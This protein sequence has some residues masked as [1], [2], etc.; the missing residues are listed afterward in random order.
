MKHGMVRGFSQYTATQTEQMKQELSIEMPLE[1]LAYC[2]AYYQ[3]KARRDPYIEELK[4]LDRF[5]THQATLAQ[6]IAPTGLL[7]NHTALAQTYADMMQKRRELTENTAA[8]PATLQELALLCTSY[9]SRIGRTSN[10]H[11]SLL[12]DTLPDENTVCVAGSR[13]SNHV[14]PHTNEPKNEN[15]FFVLLLPH[16]G[17]NGPQMQNA[18][19]SFLKHIHRKLCFKEML[20]VG[21]EGLLRTL[22]MLSDGLLIDLER[23][24]R[25][26][27]PISATMLTNGYSGNLLFRMASDAYRTFCETANSFRLCAMAFAKPVKGTTI[28]VKRGSLAFT[29]DTAFLRGLIPILTGEAKLS[30]TSRI[31]PTSIYHTSLTAPACR[32]LATAQKATPEAV[33][34]GDV[35]CAMSHVSVHENGFQNAIYAAL[36]PILSLSAAGCAYAMQSLSVGIGIPSIEHTEAIATAL[37]AIIGIY[38]LQAEL[39][40]PAN[41][42]SFCTLPQDKQ[43]QLTFY[44]S[45]SAPTIENRF[46]EN[47]NRVY[48]M[49]PRLAPDGLPDFAELRRM[50]AALVALSK[51][52]TIK[53]ARVWMGE[54]LIDVLRRMQTEDLICHPINAKLLFDEA[55][56]PALILET[57]ETLDAPL[58]GIVQ[59]ERTPVTVQQ[60]LLLPE[61]ECLI[62]YDIPEI[63][64]LAESCDR[65][66]DLLAS[67]LTERGA[68]VSR[69]TSSDPNRLARALLGC[70]T[71][72]ICGNATLPKTESVMF[73]AETLH[74][75]NGRIITVKEGKCGLPI[76]V[77]T[78]KDGIYPEMLDQISKKRNLIQKK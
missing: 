10:I 33:Q 65:D 39:A 71:L 12:Q 50:L 43:T 78:L 23:L 51:R 25:T 21:D 49:A 74:R 42:I 17:M 35:L 19:Q 64:L 11:S 13:F 56:F 60:P 46:V 34:M 40:L 66:A 54:A 59:K 16:P 8:S 57:T 22:T 24:S 14:T 76:P 75:A 3:S 62:S 30:D 31:T 68:H 15:D 27:E 58:V 1:V 67:I 29:I 45:G 77:I 69:L 9:L 36:V 41:Q 18:Q 47:G 32:Y 63:L 52:G 38:R 6:N 37:S 20:T 70:E 2:A 72:I 61:R 7:T 48:C 28:T 26:G 73:A 4:L 44:A 53:S 55:C 5:W